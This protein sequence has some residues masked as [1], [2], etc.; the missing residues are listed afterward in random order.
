M[1]YPLSDNEEAIELATAKIFAE[2]FR[3]EIGLAK[4]SLSKEENGEEVKKEAS[5]V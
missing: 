1:L 3:Q 4:Y 2:N 5:E